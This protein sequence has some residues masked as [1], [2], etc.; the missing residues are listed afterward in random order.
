MQGSDNGFMLRDRKEAAQ[1]LAEKL[2]KL[3]PRNALILAIP[4]GG[5]I[6]G[7]VIADAVGAELDIVTPRKLHDREDPEL[8]IGAVMPD[9]STFLNEEIIR[10]RGVSDSYIKKE[11]ELQIA[12]SSRRLKVYRGERPYPQIKGRTVVLVD[13]GIAT[14]AT[15]FAALR[16]AKKQKA[17]RII[18]AVPVIPPETLV[19]LRGEADEVVYLACPEF[20]YAIGQFYEKFEQVEDSEATL[21]LRG[22]WE[23]HG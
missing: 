12:E 20:F 19:A 5:I 11:K 7:A 13:D 10:I 15:M 9:G 4:R 2:K 6:I 8:A 21:L 14:G 16:W 17:A 18:V 23:K 22:Y 1:L 3:T